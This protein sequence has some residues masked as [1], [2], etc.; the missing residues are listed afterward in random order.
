M[1]TGQLFRTLRAAPFR[2]FMMHVADGREILV[3]HLELVLFAGGD[4][5]MKAIDVLLV[6]SLRPLAGTEPRT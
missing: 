1:T 4:G 5:L 6:V 2:T 3:R